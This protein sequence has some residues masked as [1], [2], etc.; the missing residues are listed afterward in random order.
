MAGIG[1]PAQGISSRFLRGI[2][3]ALMGRKCMRSI[4]V[5]FNK[6]GCRTHEKLKVLI[7][8]FDKQTIIIK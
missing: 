5:I 6:K 8:E 1:A 4:V 7:R 2:P 3:V